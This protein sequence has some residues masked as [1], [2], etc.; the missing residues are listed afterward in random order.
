MRAKGLVIYRVLLGDQPAITDLVHTVIH[1]LAQARGGP[2]PLL[3]TLEAHFAAGCVVTETARQLHL[4]VRAVTYRLERIAGLSGYDPTDP[5]HRVTIHAAVLGARLIGWPQH[6]LP[7]PTTAPDPAAPQ[8]TTLS[9]GSRQ[10][11]LRSVG[12]FWLLTIGGTADTM[13]ISPGRQTQAGHAG[14][15]LFPRIPHAPPTRH[16]LSRGPAQLT[17]TDATH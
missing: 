5:A 9:A 8:P 17:N 14:S 16:R 10:P 1:P 7:P 3:E 2:G 6:D 13:R 4:S 11:R 12:R 15:V